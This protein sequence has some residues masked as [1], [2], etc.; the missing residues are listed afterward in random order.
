M[1][2]YQVLCTQFSIFLQQKWCVTTKIKSQGVSPRIYSL[3]GHVY[4]NDSKEVLYLWKCKVCGV[5]P[6]VGKAKIKL[7]YRF[8]HYKS[9]HR[10]FRKDN[11]QVPQ[12][13][14]HT[15][16]CLDDHS[17]NEDWDFVIFEKC[18][19]H[20]QLKERETFWQHRLKTFY[21]IGLKKIILIQKNIII[22][23]IFNKNILILNIK[24]I[25]KHF[26][27]IGS[28]SFDFSIYFYN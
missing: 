5:V 14:F 21:P 26:S 3:Q 6:Y 24:K 8:D 15:H 25:F 16:Y 19:T 17:G 18:E 1:S 12:K 23:N 2:L 11:R 20:A 10:A 13:L 7:C 4:I 9:K 28:E 22:L 27:L